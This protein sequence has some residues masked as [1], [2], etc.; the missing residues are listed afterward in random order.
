MDP[1]DKGDTNTED[2]NTLAIEWVVD[3]SKE[4][5]FTTEQAVITMCAHQ[6]PSDFH[7]LKFKGVFDSIP[8]CILIDT[9][10]THSFI[11][12][13]LVDTSKW[14]T[15]TTTP[16]HVR[17]ANGAAMATSLK[18]P[19]L[20]F[21]LQNHKMSGE[22]RLLNIQGY[23]LILGMDWLAL[24]GPM[25]IDWKLGQLQLFHNNQKLVFQVQNEMSEVKVCQEI[26]NPVQEVKKGSLMLLA[27]IFVADDLHQN[28]TTVPSQ[29]QP[30]LDAFQHV[31]QDPT[32]LPPNRSVDHTIPLLPDSKPVSI[33][34]Y[35][36]SYFQREE[37]E[38]IIGDLLANSFIRPSTSPYSSPV[39][40]VKKKDSSWRLCIDYRQLNDM[41]VKN[42]YPI[43]IIDDLLDELKGACY[44]SKIDLKSGYHQIRMADS[45]IY[46]TAFRTH[47]G[48][49]EFVVM[50]FGL[51]NAPAT[52]QTLM[53]NL[54]QPFLRK[55]VLVF[56]DDI[57]IYSKSLAEHATHLTQTPPAQAAFDQ[58]K[59]AMSTA[60]V[61][62]LPD[63]S[64]QFIIETDASAL[65]LGAVLMQD[66]KP[67]AYLSKSLGLKNQGLSTYEKELLALLTA[68]C[69]INKPERVPYPGL[70]QPLPIPDEAWQSVAQLFLDNIYKLHGLPK[71][72]VSDRDPVFTSSFWK[73][74]MAKIG[75][76][77]NLSTAYHPQSDGQT[78]RLNQCLEQYLRCMIFDQ[79]KQWC[80]WLP[81]AEYWYNTS[82]QQS[83][84]TSPFQA[85]YGY[86]PQLL[87]LG[88]VIRS[89]NVAVNVM[90]R[91]RQKALTQ[92]RGNLVKAQSR[93]KKY[94]DLKRC[95]RHFQEG[96]WVF[97]TMQPYKHTSVATAGTGK[98]S[99]RYFGPFEILEKIG[100]LAYKLN[101][102]AAAHIHPVIHVS[103]LKKHIGRRH[104]PIP[105][106]PWVGPDGTVKGA[107]EKIL[108]RRLV[109]RGNEGIVQLKVKWLNCTEA[110][111]TWEDFDQLKQF[112]PQFILEVEN[113]FMEWGM[114][115]LTCQ[116]SSEGNKL[117]I[118]TQMAQQLEQ[119][120]LS[121]EVIPSL[122]E[123]DGNNN[124]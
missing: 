43:P 4:E 17:I 31:F 101:L 34:P 47:H 74:L 95:E 10:S 105:Y 54:F 96:D 120:E 27:H 48:H 23:D 63:Y 69:Q 57:L 62:T 112:Y 44:F 21:S 90:L 113:N 7:T 97:L 93:M 70:L 68:S 83:L 40:L 49:F 33:R 20:Q 86:Q 124:N 46:K 121:G 9:G 51:T 123:G 58:L 104:V 108:D 38:S 28:I 84:N 67:I 115:Q 60:P 55:Y 41:T 103:Q 65:G 35:R 114:S 117:G 45:D 79:Q 8:I 71:N 30:V 85:L 98:L 2:D 24:H 110:D 18:C 73:E 76:Q 37:I 80:R 59:L 25:T 26:L 52:F 50:P 22:M 72:L 3:A 53:N 19:Q 78:E 91:D 13:S 107:P 36:Y 64:K 119:T 56:F 75:I 116:I 6:E 118:E 89:T 11:N 102:P 42:K 5:L 94:A 77:L 122:T 99:S 82:Y 81:L 100:N 15:I 12:P 32:T 109:K 1:T 61:L 66:N 106:C 92:I 88:D 39:L 16:L 111:A 29:L 87:P 14:K